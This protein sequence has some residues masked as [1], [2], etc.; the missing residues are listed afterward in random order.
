MSAMKSAQAQDDTRAS[1]ELTSGSEKYKVAL[2]KERCWGSAMDTDVDTEQ[3]SGGKDDACRLQ[4]DDVGQALSSSDV[5][6][7]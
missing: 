4:A 2:E 6:S 3:C 5:T 1:L 7:I